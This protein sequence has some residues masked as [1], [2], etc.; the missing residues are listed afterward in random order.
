MLDRDTQ[1]Y[2][3]RYFDLFTHPGWKDFIKDNAARRAAL[4]ELVATHR[5][6]EAD[7]AYL[8]GQIYAIDFVLRLDTTMRQSYDALREEAVVSNAEH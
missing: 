2:Y 3:E 8:Q 6:S 5:L 7:A 1:D 4:S